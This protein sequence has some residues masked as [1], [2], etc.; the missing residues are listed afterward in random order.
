[1]IDSKNIL[2]VKRLSTRL[3]LPITVGILIFD[4]VEVL[5]VTGPFEVFCVTR[6][7]EKRRLEESSPFRLLLIA[8]TQT[9]YSCWWITLHF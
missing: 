1:L 6:L 4:E 9:N 2:N 3:D 7:D 8:E 5:D